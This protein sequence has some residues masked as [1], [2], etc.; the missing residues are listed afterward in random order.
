MTHEN[1]RDIT[2]A[3]VGTTH[4]E[5]GL[6]FLFVAFQVYVYFSSRSIA[7]I[8]DNNGFSRPAVVRGRSPTPHLA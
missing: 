5:R 6:S 2:F 3:H 4:I 1:F 8:C 7:T